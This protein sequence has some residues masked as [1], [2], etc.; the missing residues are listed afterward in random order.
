MEERMK[1]VWACRQGDEPLSALCRRFEISRPTAYKWMGRYEALGLDGLADRSRAPRHHPNALDEKTREMIL[2]LRQA[3]P[4]WGPRKLRVVLERQYPRKSWPAASTIG[5]FLGRQGLSVPRK[6]RRRVERDPHPLTEGLLPND[7][8][9]IDFKGWF[10]TGDGRRCDP[11][12]LSDAASRFLLRLQVLPHTGHDA[13]RRLLEAAFRE[14]GLPGA[15]RSDN[16][17]PFA[18]RAMAGLSPLS[19]WWIKLGIAHQRI[20]PGC[21]QQNG[22]HERMHLTLKQ[23]TADPPACNGR[24]Q[25][26]RFDA[27]RDEFNDQRPHEALLMQTPGSRYGRSQREYPAHLAEV[28][29][30]GA[31]A[32]GGWLIRRVQKHGEFY[33]KNQS[34]FMSEV[35]RGE[36]IGLEPVDDRYW[37]AYFG[38]VKLGVFDSRRRRMLTRLQ[39][40]R[41]ACKRGDPPRELPSATLQAT[42]P[43]EDKV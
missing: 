31:Q 43:A 25:Q 42:L 27:F 26:E 4:T 14:F 3:H 37:Q 13:V 8:W 36:P 15:I 7:L 17:P 24:R 38:P 2:D 19:I 30:G 41:W 10:R 39:A 32:R 9:G 35:L 34:V 28:E 21:P 5:E 11:L 22:S 6:R 1:F 20:D 16:G 29:Y 40:K 23:E 18:S 33:W 12:T